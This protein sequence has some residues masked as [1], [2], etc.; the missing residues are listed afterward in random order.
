MAIALYYQ[1][2][3]PSTAFRFAIIRSLAGIRFTR[4]FPALL[5]QFVCCL[6]IYLRLFRAGPAGLAAKLFSFDYRLFRIYNYSHSIQF[7]GSGLFGPGRREFYCFR[8]I[9]ACPRAGITHHAAALLAPLG[10]C[11]ICSAGLACSPPPGIARQFAT[12]TTRHSPP[13]LLHTGTWPLIP[14]CSG[15]FA[16]GSNYI[17]ML[18]IYRPHHIPPFILP[19]IAYCIYYLHL[20][21]AY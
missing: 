5:F 7:A 10:H 11:C 18:H 19:F 14:H 8:L 2:F 16:P 21:I 15:Q 12:S 17:A 13:L 1:L 3:Q 6:G 4:Q 20:R 9:A